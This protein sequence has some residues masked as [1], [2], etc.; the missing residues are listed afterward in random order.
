MNQWNDKG[1]KRLEGYGIQMKKRLDDIGRKYRALF[2]LACLMAALAGAGCGQG[3]SRKEG[4]V[5]QA[6]EQAEQTTGLAYESAK[7]GKI[8]FAALRE[9]NPDI[10]AW[11]YVPGTGVDCPI[12]QSS[13]SD[14]FYKTHTPDGKEDSAGAVYT[15]MP[16]MMNMCDFNTVIHGKDREESDP[17]ADLHQLEDPDFFAGHEKFY[18]YLPDNVL[19]YEIFAVY[20]DEG[21]DIL[22]RF[23]YTTYAGCQAYLEQVYASREMGKLLREGWNDL[24]PYHFLV[25]LDGSIRETEEKQFVVIGVLIEDAAGQIDR[26]I[27]DW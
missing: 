12:L 21:S 20:H 17:F 2:F 18:I 25:T 11:L 6:G 9:E 13:V 7:D 16:N 1:R 26:V 24:T 3:E 10:F 4:T 14:D 27:L 23:D 19:T 8:D 5:K 22:R 15:E